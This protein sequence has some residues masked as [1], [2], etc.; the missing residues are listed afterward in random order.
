MKKTIKTFL[1]IIASTLF[2]GCAGTDELTP[3]IDAQ[4]PQEEQAVSERE[5]A[6]EDVPSPEISEV[7]EP[8]AAFIEETSPA[9][10]DTPSDGIPI[11]PSDL[12]EYE[13]IKFIHD[14]LVIHVDYDYE[15][16]ANDTLP[17]EAFTAQGALQ[18]H[19][20]VCEGYARAVSLLCEKAGIEEL[21]VFGEADDGTGRQSHAWNQVQIDGQ[22]Y[23]LDVT[24]DDPLVNGE[25][26]TDGTNLIYDYFLVP[27]K[28]LA[29][30]HSPDADAVTHTCTSSRYLEENRKLS[31]EPYRE[32]PFFFAEADSDVVEAIP[33]YLSQEIFQFQVIYD[34]SLGSAE[35]KMDFTMEQVKKAME[36]Q[37]IYGQISLDARSGIADYLI[38]TVMI[39]PQ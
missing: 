27:D 29:G 22:W 38:V 16:L 35:K 15:N 39:S 37:E 28:S 19:S 30:T 13:K 21:L 20:A 11:V 9:D 24:W 5:P 2:A 32:E 4:P 17:D 26:V 10:D 6:E 33:R 31:I 1:L 7:Q 14:Y 12:S 36:A 23:N 18:N 8:S 25:V 3:I 34:I